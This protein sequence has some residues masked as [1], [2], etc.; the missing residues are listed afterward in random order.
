MNTQQEIDELKARL[1]NLERKRQTE[2]NSCR[3]DWDQ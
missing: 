1:Q 3:H 2:I